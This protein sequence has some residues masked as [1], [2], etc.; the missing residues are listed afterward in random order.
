MCRVNQIDNQKVTVKWLRERDQNTKKIQSLL[1]IVEA[2]H[3]SINWNSLM[4]R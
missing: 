3:Q 4:D 1:I 2:G